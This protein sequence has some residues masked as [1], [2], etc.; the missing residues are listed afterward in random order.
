[1][2]KPLRKDSPPNLHVRS[3][4]ANQSMTQES[5][6][7]TDRFALKL[8]LFYAAYF[9]YGGVQLPFFPLWLESRGLDASAIGVVIAVPM[10]VRIIFT[11][12][13]GHQAD[14]RS[15][16]PPTYSA[17]CG[18]HACVASPFEPSSISLRP[19]QRSRWHRIGA[20]CGFLCA[21]SIARRAIHG[22]SSCSARFAARFWPCFAVWR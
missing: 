20:A 10:V 12:I 18:E 9:L 14:R 11:P 21:F 22:R 8:G 3:R 6:F 15:A 19:R 16:P 4:R 7:S 17:R 13:I 5:K 1:M 2:C